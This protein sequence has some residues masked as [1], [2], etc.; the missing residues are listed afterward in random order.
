MSSESPR[1]EAKLLS[2][3]APFFN[4]VASV[5]PFC[6]R[7]A[8]AARETPLEVVLVDDGSSDGTTELIATLANEH[9]WI[10]TVVLSRNFGHQAAL[11]AGLEHARGDVV[12]MLDGDLQDPPEMI[13]E[14]LE[15]WRSGS[16]VVYAVREA[17][18]G[19]TRFKLW[20]ASA[21]YRLFNRV[22]HM[23]IPA[24][25]GDFRLL[26]RQALDALLLL[27]ERRRFLR[28]MT[29]WVGFTQ[30]AIPYERDE[31]HAGETKYPLH[32]MVRFSLD[33]IMS[34]SSMPLRLATVIGL[35]C[36]GLSVVLLPLVV[37]A[38]IFDL[39]QPGIPTVLVA[40]LFL[41]GVQ[42]ISIGMIGE[43]VG[44]IYDEVKQRPLYLVANR[45]EAETAKERAS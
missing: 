5:R 24:D 31:R 21:F 45:T 37:V 39:F 8:A 26:D 3:V 33:A 42:L 43:Y 6:E 32:K 7:V 25:A 44:R 36:S 10:S 35:T 34:F 27:R 20:T 19:E 15:L 38:R 14:M 18:K 4:E 2:V 29:T 30:T 9:S 40:I 16:D 12:C 11:S 28:G 22:A 41:G 13:P 1:R 23:E 17:R